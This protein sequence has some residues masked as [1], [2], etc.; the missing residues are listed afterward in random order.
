LGGF[1]FDTDCFLT[2]KPLEDLFI[3]AAAMPFNGD[4]AVAF[5]FGEHVLSDVDRAAVGRREPIRRGLP[6]GITVL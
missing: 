4:A 6:E 1:Y 5:V 2:E 3:K